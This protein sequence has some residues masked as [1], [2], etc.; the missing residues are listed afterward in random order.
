MICILIY[1]IA[2]K[3][4]H[5]KRLENCFFRIVDHQEILFPHLNLNQNQKIK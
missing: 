3:N 2:S 5:I 4:K 1:Y